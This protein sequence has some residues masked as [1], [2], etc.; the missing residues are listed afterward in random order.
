MKLSELRGVG[1]A[2]TKKLSALGIEQVQDLLFH[3]PL[4]Y[5]DRT[6]I[7][8]LSE[9]VEGEALQACVQVRAAQ[10]RYGRRRS[11]VVYL[12]DESDAIS[13]RLFHF[14]GRQQ[15][16]LRNGTW[17]RIYGVVRRSGAQLEMVHPEYRIG[18]KS[19]VSQPAEQ[20]LSAVYPSCAGLSQN[21]LRELI[22]QA[23]RRLDDLAPDYVSGMFDMPLRQALELVH[24][25]PPQAG[26]EIDR[27]RSRLIG[28]ELLAHRLAMLS[29]RQRKRRDAAAPISNDE[30][31]TRL[32]EVLPFQPTAAQN[33]VVRE[34]R[35]DMAKPHPMLRLLQGDVG[36]GKTCVAALAAAA[37]LGQGLRVLL[38]AP[39]EIL[40]RQH[41]KTLEAWFGALDIPVVCH[42]GGQG[43]RELPATGPVLIIGTHALFHGEPNYGA[44]G[45]V[46]VDEQH[47]FGVDQRLGLKN[48]AAQGDCHPHQL[49]M[50]AT[51]IPRTL[52]Q[53][54]FADLDFSAIDEL[55]PGRKPVVTVAMPQSRRGEVIARL[56]HACAQ[57]RQ[58]YW[59]SPVIEASDWA[60]AAEDIHAELTEA[61][62]KQKVGLVH[63]RLKTK[64]KQSVMQA[65]ADAEIDVLVATTVIEV[66]VDVPNASVM[67]IDN[68][69]R[70]GLAQLHQLRGRVGRG[71]VA[72]HCLLL[73]RPPL[74][75]N[76][77]ARLEVLR[78]EHNGFRLAERD[79]E[80]RG[81]GEILGT[82]QSGLSEFRIADP[83]RDAALLPEVQ[84]LA[85]KVMAE[86]PQIVGALIMRWLPAGQ[87]YADA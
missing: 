67:V 53:T 77:R 43:E 72:S 10:I 76:G 24:Q 27:A 80:L 83:Q 19:E 30:L 37:V 61:L 40:A 22:Q 17:L 66:G 6:R 41:A 8:P 64:D 57:G 36:A 73:Y 69:E 20:R 70:L 58:A 82:R 11:L 5:E 31:A 84:N 56:R 9:A 78:T 63:G 44:V 7:Q 39:T 4:R 15:A 62:P 14:G 60:E 26:A 23:L 46:I 50:T 38:M 48:L 54:F 71:A 47:R 79:L 42:L 87:R 49:V 25:P 45:L 32:L 68:A 86:K 51:P 52:A 21:K 1:P 55:P 16:A 59:V 81:A 33:R 74:S 2:L 75:E 28:E 85:S 13:M 34:I 3:L 29:L 65:F 35:A 18:P 12:E